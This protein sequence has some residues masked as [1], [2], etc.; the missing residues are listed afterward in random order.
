VCGGR[1][2]VLIGARNV[3]GVPLCLGLQT[4]WIG[5]YLNILAKCPA[6][7]SDHSQEDPGKTSFSAL[8]RAPDA[9][10]QM[11]EQE[12]WYTASKGG[13]AD[14]MKNAKVGRV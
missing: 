1:A 13:P 7:S 8:G 11:F 10:F 4:W 5:K 3:R 12:S 6:R 14:C 9:D 2:R